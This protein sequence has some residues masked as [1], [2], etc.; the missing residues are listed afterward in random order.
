MAATIAIIMARAGSKGL[1]GK[2]LLPLAGKPLLAHTIE[3][4]LQS[5]A[6]DVVLVTT[7]DE[8]IANVARHYG[9]E[10]PFLRPAELAEDHV[11]AEP[12]IQHALLT[13][14]ELTGQTFDI[15]VYLQTTDVLRDPEWIRQCVE[16][17]IAQPNIDSVFSGYE[18][19]KRFWRRQGNRFVRLA[20]DLEYAARQVREP[21]YREDT[22]IACATRA[23]VVREGKR[24]GE[25]VDILPTTDFA[26]SVDIHTAFDLFLAEKTL[27]EWR[28]GDG[29]D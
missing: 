15:V 9:A 18:T 28:R 22:G 23:R 27:T 20:P 7:E 1:P 24:I 12:V 8:E 26:T 21:I 5:G 29:G 14:E 16:R 6:C 17:L 10:V 2:N 25:R 13:Y 19:H 11:P 3:H 4:A